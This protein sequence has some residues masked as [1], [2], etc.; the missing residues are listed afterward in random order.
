MSSSFSVL[1][2]T[3]FTFGKCL[4]QEV[5]KPTHVSEMSCLEAHL[6]GLSA[7]KKI[8]HWLNYCSLNSNFSQK[9]CV[10][11]AIFC[12]FFDTCLEKGVCSQFRLAF[13]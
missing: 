7:G 13:S 4:Q 2:P 8:P 11:A 6:V 3:H 10:F 5:F 12:P 9:V 1:Y